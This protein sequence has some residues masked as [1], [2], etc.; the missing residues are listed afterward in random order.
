[1][2][3][4]DRRRKGGR[5]R[6][7]GLGRVHTSCEAKACQRRGWAKVPGGQRLRFLTAFGMTGPVRNDRSGVFGAKLYCSQA[8]V[9]RQPMR[10]GCFGCRSPDEVRVRAGVEADRICEGE[11]AE[12]LPCEQLSLDELKGLPEH[13]CHVWYVPVADV[14]ALD[15]SELLHRPRQDSGSAVPGVLSHPPGRPEVGSLVATMTPWHRFMGKRYSARTDSG[16]YLR[17]L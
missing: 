9:Q 5:V 12:V 1:M 13:L 4:N 15:C 7:A 16:G 14:R 2:A 10:G 3:R 8:L 17:C 11:V 6:E